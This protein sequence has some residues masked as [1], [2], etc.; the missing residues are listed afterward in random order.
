M[1]PATCCHFVPSVDVQARPCVDGVVMTKTEPDVATRAPSAPPSVQVGC[2]VVRSVERQAPPPSST[3]TAVFPTNASVTKDDGP[4]V[5]RVVCSHAVPSVVC[6]I[7][8]PKA[9]GPV[10]PTA[11]PAIAPSPAIEAVSQPA[12]DAAK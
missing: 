1:G 8:L 4:G 10:G 9:T 2:H 12:A 7:A 11:M 5:G 3:P 6:Q